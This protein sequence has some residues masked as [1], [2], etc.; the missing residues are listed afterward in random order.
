MSFSLTMLFT[1]VFGLKPRVINKPAFFIISYK[2]ISLLQCQT[3]LICISPLASLPEF[4]YHKL[5]S[6]GYQF[7]CPIQTN[8]NHKET[9]DEKYKGERT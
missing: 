8:K 6:E 4:C 9:G 5:F 2:L 1:L 3:S 7:L